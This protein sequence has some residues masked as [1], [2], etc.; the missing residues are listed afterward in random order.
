MATILVIDD[1]EYIRG[2]VV[3]I[4]N[5]KGHRILEASD[6]ERGMR[7]LRAERPSI[8]ISDLLMPEKDGIEIIQ[9]IRKEAPETFVIAISGSVTA[10]NLSYLDIAKKLGADAALAK[11]F[12]PAELLDAIAKAVD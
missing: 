7:Q 3:R 4:L 10:D 5:G 11:P 6:G 2:I 8:V 1:D 12:R 9:E